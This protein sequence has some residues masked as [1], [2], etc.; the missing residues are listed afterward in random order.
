M[1]FVLVLVLLVIYSFVNNKCDN[2]SCKYCL[3]KACSKK[4]SSK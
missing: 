1:P 4:V 2:T 3:N